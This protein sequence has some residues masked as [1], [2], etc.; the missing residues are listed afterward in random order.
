MSD[1]SEK[2]DE[3]LKTIDSHAQQEFNNMMLNR[4]LDTAF[5]YAN[6]IVR[7]SLLAL[8]TLQTSLHRSGSPLILWIT[9][10][11]VFLAAFNIILPLLFHERR[12]RQRQMVHDRRWR[13]YIDIATQLRC[14]I[15]DIKTAAEAF[16]KICKVSPADAL[17]KVP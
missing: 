1:P 7:L 11:S 14:D 10:T 3:L 4:R 9:I 13:Q 2:K 15:I 6:W 8:A 5:G 17:N 12:F 16:A